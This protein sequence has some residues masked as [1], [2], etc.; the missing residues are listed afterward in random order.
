MHRTNA[1]KALL[2]R[3]MG[4]CAFSYVSNEN[5]VQGLPVRFVGKTIME[6]N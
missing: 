5:R 1:L 2:R 3:S 4:F 6:G